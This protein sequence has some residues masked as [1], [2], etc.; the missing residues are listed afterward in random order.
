MSVTGQRKRLKEGIIKILSEW[1][2]LEYL[3]D[4]EDVAAYIMALVPKPEKCVMYKTLTPAN[5][6][7]FQC[8]RCDGVQYDIPD[9]YCPH[10]ARRIIAMEDMSLWL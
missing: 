2:M 9:K 1:L 7:Y 8:S 6:M 10:C 4:Y 5:V 3:G